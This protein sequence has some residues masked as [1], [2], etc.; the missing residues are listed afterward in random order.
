MFNFNE[1][2]HKMKYRRNSFRFKIIGIEFEIL[3][4]IIFMYWTIL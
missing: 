3:L 4:S 2:M 1:N